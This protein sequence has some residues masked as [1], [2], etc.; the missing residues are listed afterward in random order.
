[1]RELLELGEAALG[2]HPFAIGYVQTRREADNQDGGRADRQ[3]VAPQQL[4]ATIPA[5]AGAGENRFVTEV[6]LNI[7]GQIR[8][9]AI[10]A[11]LILLQRLGCDGFDVTAESAIDGTEAGGFL[12]ANGL[13]GLR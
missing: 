6:T 5:A 1:M 3:A 2:S 4:R 9:R 10:A 8:G 12:F 13:N 7:G 11:R